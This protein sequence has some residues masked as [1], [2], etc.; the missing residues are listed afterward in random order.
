MLIVQ[1]AVLFKFRQYYYDL[2]G[3]LYSLCDSWHTNTLDML[4][5]KVPAEHVTQVNKEVKYH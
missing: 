2:S 3:Y 5:T 1:A 4:C